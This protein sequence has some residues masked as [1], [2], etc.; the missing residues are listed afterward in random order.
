MCG[1]KCKHCKASARTQPSEKELT[2][3]ESFALIDQIGEFGKPY[4]VLRITGGNALMRE[5]IFSLI[6]YSTSRGITTTIA[7]STTPQLSRR[8][9]KKLREAGTEVVA[10]SIDGKDRETH[11]SFRGV[12]GVFD[13]LIKSTST[14]RELNLPFRLLT[15]VTKF[16]VEQLPEIMELSYRLGAVGW[17]LYMLIPTGRAKREYALG[18]REYEDVFHFIYDAMKEAPMVVNAIAGSEPYRR[19]AVTRRLVE[20]GMLEESALEQGELYLR[21]RKKFQDI[22]SKYPGNEGEGG[23]YRAKKKG[24]G[25]GIFVAHEGQV[26]PSSFLPLELG[27]VR[28]QKLKD[29]YSSAKILEEMHDERKLKGKCGRCEFRD[30][31]RGSRS[32]A[33]AVT[34]DYL[35]EDPYCAYTPG[36]ISLPEVDKSRILEELRVTNFSRKVR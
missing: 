34:G 22:V 12:E 4:P 18:P 8:N 3:E 36:R 14:M 7:P 1:L 28:G 25:K 20:E 16:N 30:I 5:D 32:R 29:I 31:C 17:Y 33:F 9:I 24:M 6:D 26:Y 11:D 15:T 13:Q 27:E 23:N 35:A 21:L 2:T 10:L 19:V